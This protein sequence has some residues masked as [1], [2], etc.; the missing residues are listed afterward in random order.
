MHFFP[1]LFLFCAG[2][3][4]DVL[5]VLLA[6]GGSVEKAVSRAHRLSALHYFELTTTF[7]NFNYRE[8]GGTRCRQGRG[9]R[10]QVYSRI[11]TAMFTTH[12]LLYLPLSRQAMAR[13]YR[14]VVV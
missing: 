11:F 6:T 5:G 7:T 4:G 9:A 12:V 2:G 3:A 13:T 1:L 14:Y 8:S 10:A